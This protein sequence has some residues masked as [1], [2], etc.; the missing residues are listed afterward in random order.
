[1]MPE[2][3]D[4]WTALVV[5]DDPGLGGAVGEV[6]ASF[7][8]RAVV[9]SSFDEAVATFR[10][11][12]AH[13][14]ILDVHVRDRTGFDILR[15]LRLVQAGHPAI[16]MSGAFDDEIL[17]RAGD[18]DAFSMLNKPLELGRLRDAIGGL[19]GSGRIQCR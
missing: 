14:S 13:F 2:R 6:L 18:L 11:V 3:P 10:T 8:C 15:E 19:L 5:D 17:R 7:D 16:F 9:A 4:V 12:P 1:M